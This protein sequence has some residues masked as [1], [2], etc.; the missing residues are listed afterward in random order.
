MVVSRAQRCCDGVCVFLRGLLD[1]DGGREAKRKGWE[2]EVFIATERA[3]MMATCNALYRGDGRI[4][5]AVDW[6]RVHEAGERR[7]V[8]PDRQERHGA[9][10]SFREC[11]WP[12]RSFRA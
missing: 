5:V 11:N 10:R 4:L 7:M 1:G 9:G 2:I 12:S 3:E 6:K 8:S